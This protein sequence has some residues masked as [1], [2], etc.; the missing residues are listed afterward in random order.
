MSIAM[1]QLF[2]AFGLPSR[3][4]VW[5][6][7][8]RIVTAFVFFALVASVAVGQSYAS[9]SSATMAEVAVSL[10]T[11]LDDGPASGRVDLSLDGHCV[12]SWTFDPEAGGIGIAPVAR[13]AISPRHTMP[14]PVQVGIPLRPPRKI[15]HL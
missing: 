2:P 11:P 12:C 14:D 4:Q 13:H 9:P 8:S 3:G 7:M 15:D 6:V 5:R 1:P 10:P